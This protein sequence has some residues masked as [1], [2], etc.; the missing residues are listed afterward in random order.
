MKRGLGEAKVALFPC[1]FCLL[2]TLLFDFPY[3]RKSG[4]WL[5]CKFVK[6]AHG[7][8][9]LFSRHWKE[10]GKILWRVS[11]ITRPEMANGYEIYFHSDPFSR[12][13]SQTSLTDH[14]IP[15]DWASESFLKC[16]NSHH[17]LVS[18]QWCTRWDLIFQRWFYIFT[19]SLAPHDIID[20]GLKVRNWGGFTP[21]NTQQSAEH[22]GV[23]WPDGVK[24]C[25]L[26]SM[27]MKWT[28]NRR[29]EPE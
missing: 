23:R 12:F 9:T 1:S 28:W 16:S 11:W 25:A 5:E 17:R 7:S 18:Q 19:S 21:R 15:S 4:K 6:K 3:V 29:T 14:C 27:C 22:K 20:Q 8:N 2:R 10:L 13:Y 24:P 26:E